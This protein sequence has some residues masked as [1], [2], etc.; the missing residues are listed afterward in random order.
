M[1]L[2]SFSKQERLYKKKLIDGIFKEGK[3]FNISPFRVIVQPNPDQSGLVNQ[4]LFTV[5]SKFFKRAVDR[6]LLKRRMREVYRMNKSAITVTTKL[7]LAYIYTSREILPFEV[8]REKM[9]KSFER[10]K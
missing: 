3:S 5:P 2:Q 7:L 4:V 1:K 6:N 10:L 8:I 9:I